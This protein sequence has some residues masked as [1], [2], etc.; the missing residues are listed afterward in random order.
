MSHRVGVAITT[1]NRRDIL[2]RF[3][4]LWQSVTEGR[5]ELVIIDDASMDPVQPMNGVHVVR[6]GS[7][8]GVAGSKNRC[9]ATLM[10]LGVEHLFLADDDM[11][12]ISH[13]ALDVYINDPMPHLMHCWGSKRHIRSDGRYS[14]WSHPRGV[15][16]YVER[17]VVESVGGMRLEFGRWGGEHVEWSRR[18]HAAGFTPEPFMDT[19]RSTGL[20]ECLDYTRRHESTVSTAERAAT[21]DMRNSLASRF[22]GSREFVPYW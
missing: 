7:M 6:N 21:K 8:L 11:G 9:I 5:A 15:L 19:V 16:L 14:Y 2:D 20:W 18:I 1:Q 10:D 13:S 22:A 12:P 4:P 17:R 3:V